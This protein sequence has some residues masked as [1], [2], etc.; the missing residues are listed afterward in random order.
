MNLFVFGEGQ[1]DAKTELGQMP[2]SVLHKDFP[3]IKMDVFPKQKNQ[4]I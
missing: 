1:H 4:A 3:F 2:R